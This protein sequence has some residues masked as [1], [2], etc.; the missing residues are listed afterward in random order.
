MKLPQ[1]YD[2]VI[3]YLQLRRRINFI[4]FSGDPDYDVIDESINLVPSFID[5]LPEG[6][7]G[8]PFEAI[9]VHPDNP[10]WYK[11]SEKVNEVLDDARW[12]EDQV[13]VLLD[14]QETIGDRYVSDR[15]ARLFEPVISEPIPNFILSPLVRAI[16]LSKEQ[17]DS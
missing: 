1:T 9:A 12:H 3:N 16:C 8:C 10:N 4:Y 17:A 13:Y 11:V 5:N 6:T 2:E 15:I 14:M 7:D